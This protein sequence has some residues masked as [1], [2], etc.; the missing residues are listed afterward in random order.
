M[1]NGG[2]PVLKYDLMKEN[3]FTT[4][5]S[6]LNSDS[7]AQINIFLH[8]INFNLTFISPYLSHQLVNQEGLKSWICECN[9][10][11]NSKINYSWN[12]LL[13]NVY[14]RNTINSECIENRAFTWKLHSTAFNL[15]L[16]VF[17]SNFHKGTVRDKILWN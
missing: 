8:K 14:V 5:K 13:A 15:N 17:L 10:H 12:E 3:S 4:N 11:F 1:F 9:F 6:T 16:H 7:K 2:N